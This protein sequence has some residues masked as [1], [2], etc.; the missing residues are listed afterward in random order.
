MRTPPIAIVGRSCVLPGAQSPEQ[1]WQAVL[2]GRDLLSTTPEGRWGVARKQILC[3]PDGDSRDRAWC[4][5]GGYVQDFQ[6]DAQGYGLP[7]RELRGLDP[8]FQLTL[9]CCREALR[10]AGA[11]GDPRT[12]AILGNLGFPSEGL[13]RFAE[14]VWLD[15]NGSDRPDPRDRFMSG[16]PVLLLEG[17]CTLRSIGQ[18]RTRIEAFV[19]MLR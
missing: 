19:E 4:E 13:A 3:E 18:H 6:F 14:S 12:A 8:L 15:R 5:R 7:A 11:T 1:L 2:E 17:D 10:D 9:H 16:L